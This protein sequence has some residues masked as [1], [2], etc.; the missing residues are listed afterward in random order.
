LVARRQRQLASNSLGMKQKPVIGITSYGMNEVGDYHLPAAYVNAV[1]R[2]GGLPVLLTPDAGE[3]DAVCRRL[4][5]V[6]LSGGG[7]M[8][9]K[10]YNGRTHAEI[11]NIDPERDEGE[12]RVSAAV[13][14]LNL[15]TLAICRGVQMLN[16]YLG[17][18][19]HEHLPEVYGEGILH[20]RPPR[21]PT[22]HTVEITPGSKLSD[23]LGKSGMEIVSWHHQ[24]IKAVGQGL[25]VSA[26]SRDGVIEAVEGDTHPWLI[27]VQW[28]PEL[29]A[30]TD[31]LQQKLFEA[32][33]T[34]A[35]KRR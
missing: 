4:D 7:D 16:V 26:R 14:A 18:T 30:T 21:L 29:T 33:V 13:M 35:R 32:L 3:A 15:P 34:Q 2:A 9:P 20:R 6:I 27:G 11:Y 8:D 23:I 10:Y 5:G 12:F 19:L 28:H 1:R 25:A 31:P 22:T 17:G 24:C